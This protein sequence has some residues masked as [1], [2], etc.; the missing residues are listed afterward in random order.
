MKW[1]FNKVSEGYELIIETG[2]ARHSLVITTL[3]IIEKMNH[4]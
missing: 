4:I 2:A 3:E 1:A